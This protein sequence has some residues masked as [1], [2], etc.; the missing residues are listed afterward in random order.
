MAAK[1]VKL[2]NG[3]VCDAAARRRRTRRDHAIAASARPPPVL[4]ARARRYPRRS[5]ARPY[6][7]RR[8]NDSGRRKGPSRRAPRIACPMESTN[9][10]GHPSSVAAVC[11]ASLRWHSR[12]PARR[13][14][15]NVLFHGSDTTGTR[16]TRRTSSRSSRTRRSSRSPRCPTRANSSPWERGNERE[17]ARRTCPPLGPPPRRVKICTWSVFLNT[18][19]KTPG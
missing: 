10:R 15:T 14:T 5:G 16:S 1:A 7:A 12:L 13:V 4:R 19:S 6:T 9:F 2:T 17:R 11:G 8:E 18:G 3:R